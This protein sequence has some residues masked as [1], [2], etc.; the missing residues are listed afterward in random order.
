MNQERLLQVLLAPHVSEKSATVGERTVKRSQMDEKVYEP[1]PGGRLL[2]FSSRREGDGGDRSTEGRCVP[3]G[4]TV[5]LT[6][7]GQHEE[8]KLGPV[9]ETA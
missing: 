4:C 3:E 5:Q 2:A 7:Q 6:A 8:R 9:N 1:R